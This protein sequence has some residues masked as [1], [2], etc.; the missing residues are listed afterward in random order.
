MKLEDALDVRQ[1]AEVE[2]LVGLVEHERFHAGKHEV[3]LPGKVEK[4][5]RGADDD[6][7][8]RLE[9]LDLRLVRAA[10][11]DGQYA[12]TGTGTGRGVR[13]PFARG[14]YVP[15]DLDGEFARRHDDERA[16]LAVAP[17]LGGAEPLQQRDAECESLARAGP[18]L[19]DDV[20]SAERDRQRERLDGE[21]VGDP[22]RFERVAYWV[23]DAEITKRQGRWLRRVP[24]VWRALFSKGVAC[25]GFRLHHEAVKPRVP[26]AL[27]ACR[28]ASTE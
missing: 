4:P 16:G 9:G 23:Y 3:T 20:M 22:S 25:Q 26:P 28:R 18:G 14:L 10:A 17:Q 6:V 13:E 19:A 11:V 15:G 24:F 21:R 5:A 2:H 12:G 27:A 7:D 8:A 1:E